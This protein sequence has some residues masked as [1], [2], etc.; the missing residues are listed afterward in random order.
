MILA[1]EAATAA[2]GAR[3]AG[4]LG[5]SDV[6]AL[7]GPLGVGKTTLVRALLA[8]LGHAGEVP[9]PSF[10]IV[11]PYEA[12][13]PPVLHVDLFRV[14]HSS[15]LA[16]LGLDDAA[17]AAALLVEWPERA[18]PAAWPHALRLSLEFVAGGAR[19]LTAEVPPPWEGRWPPQP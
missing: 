5:A 15:E 11:Q 1:D 8:A 3:L 14:E 16:E 17:T 19:R 9:S 6:I 4:L 2:L 7:T 18:G 10:A 13:D 12:L